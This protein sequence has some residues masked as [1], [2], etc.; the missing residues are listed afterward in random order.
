MIGVIPAAGRSSRIGNPKPLLDADGASFLERTVGVLRE[1]GIGTV[2]VGVREEGSPIGAMAGRTG[3]RVVIPDDPDRGPVATLRAVVTEAR[4]F[5]GACIF[6]PV[7][8]PLVRPATIRELIERWRT[9]GRDLVVPVHRERRGHP[10]LLGPTLLRELGQGE[11]GTGA[12]EEDLADLLHPH[13]HAADLVEVDDRG[14]LVDID[15]LAEYRR[16][17]P[18]AYRRRFQKW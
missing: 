12:G 9:T 17:F 5:A 16:H 3:A 2:F 4:E 11:P 8:H 15:T 13:D 18:A 7:D 14:V 10:I 6:L 1:A